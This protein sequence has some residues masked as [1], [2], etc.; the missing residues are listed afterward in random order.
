[1]ACAGALRVIDTAQLKGRK[2]V[3]YGFGIFNSTLAVGT[4][5]VEVIWAVLENRVSFRVLFIRVPYYIEDSQR[6]PNLE[7]YPY[8]A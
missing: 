3:V 8:G 7:N 5:D 2:G 6:D 1:M 4:V